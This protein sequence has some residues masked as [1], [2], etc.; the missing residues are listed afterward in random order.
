MF[1]KELS[2]YIN[3][4]KEQINDSSKPISEKEL[5]YFRMFQK[6][7]QDGI[8]Y[9]KHLFSEQMVKNEAAKIDLLNNLE[10]L[11]SD[12]NSIELEPTEEFTPELLLVNTG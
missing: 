3:Y 1:I 7:M 10:I 9:Y 5:K 8:N 6:N 4:L 11:E 2:L 12:L